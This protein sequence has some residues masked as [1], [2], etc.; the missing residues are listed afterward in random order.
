MGQVYAVV[1]GSLVAAYLVV[2]RA[3]VTA[4]LGGG[5]VSMRSLTDLL[6]N[7]VSLS[8]AVALLVSACR[9]T[10][11]QR[12]PWLLMGLAAAAN[13]AGDATWT[14]LSSYRHIEPYPSLADVAYLAQF[15]LAAGGLALLARSRQQMR[16]RDALLDSAITTVGLGLVLWVVLVRPVLGEGGGLEQVCTVAYPLGDLVLMAALARLLTAGGKA[17]GSFRLLIAAFTTFLVANVV[18]GLFYADDP[19]N[20]PAWSQA[21]FMLAPALWAM[22]ALHPSA[23]RL[24]ENQGDSASSFTRRRL[25]GLMVAALISPATLG[26]QLWIGTALDGWAIVVSST[27]LFVLVVMRMSSL[28]THIQDQA[29]LLATLARTDGLTGLPNRRTA[30][31]QLERLVTSDVDTG[32]TVVLLDLDRFKAFNDSL[33]HAAGDELLKTAAALWTEQVGRDGM[34][35]R[36]GG[37]EFLLILPGADVDSAARIVARMLEVT[38][39]GQTF[40]AGIASWDSLESPNALVARAD[41]ALYAAKDAGRNCAV[42]AP[43]R[44]A[45]ATVAAGAG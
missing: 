24:S 15:P 13:F 31:A 32:L 22:S 42:V 16:S 35:A 14:Y 39:F 18:L 30:D 28:L 25:L 29:R 12:L 33:G 11:A 44:G 40:S 19:V 23:A 34:L 43:V 4:A 41:A 36:F 5:L 7:T 8:A 10:R 45:Q 9:M 20:A 26:A 38:P 1:S 21:L 6:Y 27:V 37:E 2:S 3:D 17:S